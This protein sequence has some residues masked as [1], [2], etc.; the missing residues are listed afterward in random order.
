M[1]KYMTKYITVHLPNTKEN[2]MAIASLLDVPGIIV[3]TASVLSGGK[4]YVTLAEGAAIAGVN[5]FTFRKWVVEMHKIPYERPSGAGQGGV[6][7]LVENIE[8]F[9]EGRGRKS[10]VKGGKVNVLG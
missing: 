6:R 4:K 1:A 3:E 9:L 2:K 7:L 10:R 5:Y 8:S